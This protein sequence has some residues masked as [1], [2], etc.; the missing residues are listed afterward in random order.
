MTLRTTAPVLLAALLSA[1]CGPAPQP[2]ATGSPTTAATTA[3]VSSTGA[4]RAVTLAALKPCELLT[5]AQVALYG[6]TTGQETTAGSV[7]TCTYGNPSS[8]RQLV[9]SFDDVPIDQVRPDPA[10]TT[11]SDRMGGHDVL[12]VQ[13]ASAALCTLHL[14]IGGDRIVT[15][16]AANQGDAATACTHA[17]AVAVLIE[18]ALP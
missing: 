5:A 13:S 1:A 8:R 10:D 16:Q 7:R 11:G 18:P 15:V 3:S 17:R 2:T 14:D 12:R 6:Y 4:G 9:V